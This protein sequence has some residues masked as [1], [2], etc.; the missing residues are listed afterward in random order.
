M[1][2]LD[3]ERAVA[4][5]ARL[6]EAQNAYYAGGAVDGLRALLAEDVAWHVAGT[7]AIAGRYVGRDAVLTYFDRRRAIA[8]ETF[9]LHPGELLVGDGAHVAVL[10]DGTATIGGRERRWSTVGLYR[11]DAGRVAACWL[12]PLDPAEFDAIWSS[13]ADPR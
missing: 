12:L 10:T 6:H 9:R 5:L 8:S 4:L 2:G 7:N 1:T 3:R 13:D 11:F